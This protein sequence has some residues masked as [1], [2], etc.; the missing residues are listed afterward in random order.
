MPAAAR[1]GDFCIPH[2][3]PFTTMGGSGDVYANGKPINRVGDQVMPHLFKLKTKCYP[4]PASISSGSKTVFVNGRP[5]AFVGS[6]IGPMCK[7]IAMGSRD[8]F[9]GK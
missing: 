7:S 9:I 8:V 3:S 2:C 6:K 5:A 4:H 1:K